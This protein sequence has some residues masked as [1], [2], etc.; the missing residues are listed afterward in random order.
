MTIAYS[1]ED[2]LDTKAL[3]AWFKHS[4]KWWYLHRKLYET[5]H[6]FPKPVS[7]TGQPRWRFGD[8]AAWTRRKPQERVLPTGGNL[9]DFRTERARLEAAGRSSAASG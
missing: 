7:P 2:L 8:L 9:L 1:D 4:V 3:A 5:K 6:A